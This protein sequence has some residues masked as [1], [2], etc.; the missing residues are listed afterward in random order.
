MACIIAYETTG[1][2]DMQSTGKQLDDHPL[3]VRHW[4][5]VCSDAMNLARSLPS[6]AH[7][8]ATDVARLAARQFDGLSNDSEG[9]QAALNGDAVPE[10]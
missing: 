5:S 7:P 1:T 9:L 2:I 6:Y 8:P 4:C 3:L 10:L